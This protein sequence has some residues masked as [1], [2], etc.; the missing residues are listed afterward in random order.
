MTTTTDIARRTG[1]SELCREWQQA[2]RDIREGFRLV[3]EAT[4]RLQAV[5]GSE[6]RTLSVQTHNSYVNF[7]DPAEAL[8][9]LHRMVWVCIAGQLEIRTMLSLAKLK[10]FDAQLASGEGLPPIEFGSIM[11]TLDGILAQRG[12]FLR[13]KVAECYQWLRPHGHRSRSYVTNAKSLALGVGEKVI[14][15]WAVRRGYGKDGAFEVNCGHAKDNLRALDQV[16]HLL[17]GAPQSG[18][19]NGDLCEAIR[20]QT[21]HENNAFESKY[22]A[23]RCFQNGNLHLTFRRADLVDKFNLICGGNALKEAKAA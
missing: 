9:E 8:K 22:F 5:F 3:H 11:A 10:E 7:A 12:E 2:E 23:G 19:H 18:T 14:L 6:Y 15:T 16:F 4:G 20:S 17:D 13:D 1:I 21:S